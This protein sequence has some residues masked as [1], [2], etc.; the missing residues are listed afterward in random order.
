[1]P[2]LDI[3]DLPLL[4]GQVP[5]S[6]SIPI[7]V[8]DRTLYRTTGSQF[9]GGASQYL[10]SVTALTGAGT[11]LAAV[12]TTGLSIGAIRQ[13]WID[14]KL[15]T[16]IL[17]TP[18]FAGK[19]NVNYVVPSDFNGSTN[20]KHWILV[21][22]RTLYSE[23]NTARVYEGLYGTALEGNENVGVVLTWE[24]QSS[25][26]HTLKVRS[27][28]PGKVNMQANH[29]HLKQEV[30][31]VTDGWAGARGQLMYTGRTDGTSVYNLHGYGDE[32]TS[33]AVP[34]EHSIDTTGTTVGAGP[35]FLGTIKF[36][37]SQSPSLT[38][39]QLVI[40]NVT[41]PV[42][43]IQASNFYGI[44]T[45][46]PAAV[47]GLYE[48]LVQVAKLDSFHWDSAAKANVS[49]LNDRWSLK[50]L[51][52]GEV[53]AANKVSLARDTSGPA[54]QLI[55]T[56]STP[57]NLYYGQNVS[58]WASGNITGL[59]G[60]W[61]GFHSGHVTE[62]VSSTQARI[63]ARN[64]RLQDANELY[65]FSGAVTSA[66]STWAIIP[67][68]LDPD[69][70]VFQGGNVV[71]A[72][73]DANGITRRLMLGDADVTVNDEWALGVGGVVNTLRGRRGDIRMGRHSM[74]T[75]AGA[76][77][78]R[79]G[80]RII[81]NGSVTSPLATSPQLGSI[82]TDIGAGE[83]AVAF[84]AMLEFGGGVVGGLNDS[85][86]YFQVR[87]QTSGD[88]VLETWD[89]STVTSTTVASGWSD[90]AG[91]RGVIT[92]NRG[93]S[94]ISVNL[95][96]ITLYR[97][98]PTSWG[99]TVSSTATVRVGGASAAADRYNGAIFSAWAFAH[100]LSQSDM[101]FITVNGRVPTGLQ[102]GALSSVYSAPFDSSADGW[103]SLGSTM[104]GLSATANVDSIGGRDDCIELT[105]LNTSAAHTI[106]KTLLARAKRFRILMEVYRLNTNAV[107][108]GI[109]IAP[110][111]QGSS[112]LTVPIPG[113]TWTPITLDAEEQG[114][115]GNSLALI[116]YLTNAA[117]ATTYTGNGTDKFYIRNLKVQRLGAFI[118]LDFGS[119]VG[120]QAFDQTSNGFHSSLIAPC[121]HVVPETRAPLYFRLTTSGNF[122]TAGIPAGA[123]ITSIIA[124][125]ISGTP[126][127]TVG[128]SSGG[129]QFVSSVTL[130]AGRQRLT[131]AGEFSSTGAI[132]I[133]GNASC[134]VWFTINYEVN[135]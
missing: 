73:R 119:G 14:S 51:T 82:G 99:R 44:V 78:P 17:G 9:G 33:T 111:N 112:A 88:I 48:V 98:T 110:F 57:H 85:A 21:G 42:A 130:S 124:N 49:T 2:D 129:S 34:N 118:S 113:N 87:L 66:T 32:I 114:V 115:S 6:A 84:D 55:A 7:Q 67:G 135:P 72:A 65:T 80:V 134:D 5:D 20:N 28:V 10:S 69:H 39:N 102:W 29:S 59:S 101:D 61:T 74:K 15:H 68:T 52:N 58:V 103:D 1:M 40:F 30:T 123:R 24:G 131:L 36:R 26:S 70:E 31:T 107:A 122:P 18:N 116:L 83:F 27:G 16:W 127:I 90:L 64:L 38:L 91:T 22:T 86:C 60:I 46:T 108:T 105:L 89:G 100:V 45:Q 43:G 120:F 126:T 12:A 106:Q 117:G 53:N 3:N 104:F 25:F 23:Q 128:S 76:R 75:M 8:I 79:R 125:A 81:R 93:T 94:D 132:Y 50:T 37:Y 4:S 19:V 71:T 96:G 35:T 109:Q 62:I 54:D 92:I 13:T 47:N 77:D 11:T 133:G 41:G 56:W 63:R 95:N 121:D 97:G